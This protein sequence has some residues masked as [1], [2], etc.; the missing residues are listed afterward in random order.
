MTAQ[1]GTPAPQRTTWPLYAAGFTTAFGTHGIAANLT[2]EYAVPAVLPATGTLFALTRYAH[3]PR[4]LTWP[5]RA[6]RPN[7]E[8]DGPHPGTWHVLLA[9]SWSTRRRTRS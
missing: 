7:R 4:P 5:E 6:R 8:S 2:Y 9:H 3:P 1:A